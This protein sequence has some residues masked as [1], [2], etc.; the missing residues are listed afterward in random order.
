M[1]GHADFHYNRMVPQHVLHAVRWSG[2]SHADHVVRGRAGRRSNFRVINI[3]GDIQILRHSTSEKTVFSGAKNE[4]VCGLIYG[5]PRSELVTNRVVSDCLPENVEDCGK[6]HRCLLRKASGRDQT[7]VFRISGAGQR[8]RIDI[9]T[10]YLLREL[11]CLLRS[12]HRQRP[13]SE[14]V[15]NLQDRAENSEEK[16]ENYGELEDRSTACAAACRRLQMANE[17][18]EHSSAQPLSIMRR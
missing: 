3:L 2:R 16:H 8:S 13:E 4:N 14:V 1:K 7:E 10:I 9:E 5:S 15:G 11:E 6:P 18:G 17:D 12:L